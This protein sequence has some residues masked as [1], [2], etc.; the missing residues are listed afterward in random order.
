MRLQSWRDSSW[1]SSLSASPKWKLEA[2]SSRYSFTAILIEMQPQRGMRAAASIN[3]IDKMLQIREAKLDDVPALARVHVQAD[4]DTYAPLFGYRANALE[5][6]ESELRWRRA[7]CDGDTLLVASDGGKIVGLGHARD[8]RIGA[9]YLLRSHQRRG[10]GK[11]LLSA[12]LTALNKCGVA[13]AR[14]DVVA[15]N[16]SAIAFLSRL[17][18]LSSWRNHQMGWTRRYH[19]RGLCNF[20]R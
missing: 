3:T 11:A 5:P 20:N 13:E 2:R 10:I 19:R 9:L 18:C 16:E 15:S 6:T 12:L 1:S 14:F 7:L 8:A 4:W 17:W